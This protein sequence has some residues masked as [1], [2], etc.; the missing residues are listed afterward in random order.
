LEWSAQDQLLLT[1]YWEALQSVEQDYSVAV[2]LVGR[3]PPGSE[4]SILSQADSLHPVDGWY[5]TSRWNPGEIVRDS[6]LIAVPGGSTPAAVRIAMY[7][8][9]PDGG[10][11]NTP[12]LSL[13]VP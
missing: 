4:E 1:I 6:Y 7:R 9:D 13:T 8:A 5:P 10:F 3:D 2:H 11:R 12:W